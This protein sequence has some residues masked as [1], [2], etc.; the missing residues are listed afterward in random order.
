M[1][2]GKYYFELK[3]VYTLEETLRVCQFHSAEVAVDVEPQLPLE[4]EQWTW[5]QARRR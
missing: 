2:F 4:R 1:S 3:I 5:L